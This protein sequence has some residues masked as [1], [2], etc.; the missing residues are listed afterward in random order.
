MLQRRFPVP[1]V[2]LQLSQLQE[3][4]SLLS[5]DLHAPLEGGSCPLEIQRRAW[6]KKSQRIAQF[7][8]RTIAR[9]ILFDQSSKG[10]NCLLVVTEFG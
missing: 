6:D 7:R 9:R 5:V 3:G 2:K 10:S 8:I 1:L 4:T